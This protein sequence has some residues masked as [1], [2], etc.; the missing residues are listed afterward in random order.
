MVTT[1]RSDKNP[2]T[3]DLLREMV[4]TALNETGGDPLSHTGTLMQFHARLGHLS[5]D[6][7]ERMAKESYSGITITCHKRAKCVTCS[8]DKGTRTA[9][10]QLDSGQHSPIDRIGGVICSDLKGPITP[11]DKHGNKYLVTFIDYKSNYVRVF[12]ATHKNR[13]AAKFRDFVAWFEA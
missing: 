4:L 13:A 8:Q 10:P 7:I 5:F 12:A 11:Q 9:Q 2:M 3:K 6:S 1:L